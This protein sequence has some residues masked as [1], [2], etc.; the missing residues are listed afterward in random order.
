MYFSRHQV[1]GIFE[2]IDERLSSSHL[3]FE[4]YSKFALMRPHPDVRKTGAKK[5][6]HPWGIF[7]GREFEK[8]LPN[9]QHISDDYFLQNKQALRRVPVVH[10]LGAK[11]P[12][13]SKAGKIV[14]LIIT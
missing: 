13:I 12:L 8:W 14:H 10:R 5:F 9:I 2:R 11:I 7:N 3:V 6:K 4:A 1:K